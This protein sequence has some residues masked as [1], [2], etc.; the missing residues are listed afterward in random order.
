MKIAKEVWLECQCNQIDYDLRKGV[1][2]KKVY[3][4]LK[5]ITNTH[6]SQIISIIII[7]IKGKTGTPLADDN[8][9][10]DG[11]L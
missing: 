4:M 11:I 5:L 3:N 10:M 1:N 6:S 2:S 7:I 8:A 9:K